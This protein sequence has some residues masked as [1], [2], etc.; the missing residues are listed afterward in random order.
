[1]VIV[2]DGKCPL[3]VNVR[4]G[5]CPGWLFLNH[6]LGLIFLLARYLTGFN[7]VSCNYDI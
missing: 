7:L 3:M 2:R 1:M 4:Y 6:L 5:K